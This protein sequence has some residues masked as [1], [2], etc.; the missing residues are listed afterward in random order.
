MGGL[1]WSRST[2]KVH[3]ADEWYEEEKQNF[4]KNCVLGIFE[5]G[6]ETMKVKF[7]IN[8]WGVYTT[9]QTPTF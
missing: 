3:L 2:P 9:S 1:D 6:T 4:G 8:F 7:V 5:N